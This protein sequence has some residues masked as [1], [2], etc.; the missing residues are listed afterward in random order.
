[1]FTEWKER[2]GRLGDA[3][4]ARLVPR[5]DVEAACGHPINCCAPI[6]PLGSYRWGFYRRDVE[7]G[8]NCT[9]CINPTEYPC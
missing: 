5:A 2:T 8:G 7:H 6:G 1:M 9:Q 3:L 4:L